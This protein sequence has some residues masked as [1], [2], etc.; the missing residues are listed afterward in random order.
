MDNVSLTPFVPLGDV[1]RALRGQAELPGIDAS[2]R[3]VLGEV[4]RWTA[5]FLCQPHPDL[6]RSGDV[7]PYTEVS[8][9]EDLLMA[10]VCHVFDADPRPAMA[11]VMLEALREYEA[12][13]PRL[14][15]KVGLKATLVLF[16]SL[17]DLWIEA[18]QEELSGEFAARGL[19][20]GEF[21]AE[22]EAPGLHN[23]HFRPLRSPIPLLGIRAMMLTDL[24]FLMHSDD[25]LS[26]YLRRFGDA[27]LKAITAHLKSPSLHAT[28]DDV[29]ERLEAALMGLHPM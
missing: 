28:D 10:A 3:G 29:Y 9:R 20:L 25:G 14:G 16:P 15:N 21:H 5:D 22:S 7:C 11:S 8:M 26:H 1:L 13:A 12:R 2:D 6:G 23:P 17:E 4:A 24:P 19:M 27:A 18:V